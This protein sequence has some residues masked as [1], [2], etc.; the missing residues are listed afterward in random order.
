MRTM[1]DVERLD[2]EYQAQAR[3][4]RRAPPAL[5]PEEPE[6]VPVRVDPE[7]VARSQAE[8]RRVMEELMPKELM[9]D[10]SGA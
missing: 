6:P 5:M 10:A 4:S 1:A 3:M 8:L 2:R 9:P 7:E